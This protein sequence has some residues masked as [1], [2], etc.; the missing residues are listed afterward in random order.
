MKQMRDSMAGF[1]VLLVWVFFFAMFVGIDPDRS[2][3][4]DRLDKL[5]RYEALASSPEALERALNI[6][7]GIYDTL[8]HCEHGGD[9]KVRREVYVD[10][11]RIEVP[12][13]PRT[14]TAG[15]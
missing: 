6:Y 14:W 10:C 5:Q 15:L 9:F 3:W 7:E 8:L 13:R 4:R 11:T 1:D 2:I 12:G